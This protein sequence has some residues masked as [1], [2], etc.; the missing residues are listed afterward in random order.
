VKLPAGQRITVGVKNIADRSYR[1]A[2]GSLDEP[3]RSFV[4]SMS[5]DF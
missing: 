4:G 2:I 5:F 1:Q 3:G